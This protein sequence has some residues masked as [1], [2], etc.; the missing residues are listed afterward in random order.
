MWKCKH[1]Q[2]QLFV[3][4]KPNRFIWLDH[5]HR[6]YI[7]CTKEWK[8]RILR[9]R[10]SSNCTR[11]KNRFIH[12]VHLIRRSFPHSTVGCPLLTGPSPV[13]VFLQ[14]IRFTSALTNAPCQHYKHI[15]RW[16]DPATCRCVLR[17]PY[18]IMEY[19]CKRSQLSIRAC[20]VHVFVGVN[21][22]VFA[23]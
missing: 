21:V 20:D 10:R 4:I 22:C 16:C 19:V 12:R 14:V 9:G 5:Y 13:S 23:L 8:I 17:A 3:L 11:I 7:I 6:I 18:D 2:T 1:K 15:K